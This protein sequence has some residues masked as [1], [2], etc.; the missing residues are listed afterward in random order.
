MI[1]IIFHK[2]C[3]MEFVDWEMMSPAQQKIT[4]DKIS[5]KLPISF[6]QGVSLSL[7]APEESFEFPKITIAAL[8]PI[9]S[10][11]KSRLDSKWSHFL[12]SI[13]E[14]KVLLSPNCIGGPNESGMEKR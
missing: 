3:G 11:L 5:S 1:S 14:N 4:V 13:F 8:C 7:H 12:L 2:A 9:T 10:L 6:K